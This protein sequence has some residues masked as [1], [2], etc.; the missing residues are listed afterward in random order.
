MVVCGG[1]HLDALEV[2]DD[3]WVEDQHDSEGHNGL[4]ESA[5]EHERVGVEADGPEALVVVD[6]VD[7][8]V[9]L[10]E[11]QQI[12]VPL[13]RRVEALGQ[14]EQVEG[15]DDGEHGGEEGEGAVLKH[16]FGLDGEFDDEPALHRHRRHQPHAQQRQRVVDV[17]EYVTVVRVGRGRRVVVVSI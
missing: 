15:E 16:A 17:D 11:E 6:L 12:G 9:A 14:V 2:V 3:E 8:V 1:G 7:E 10:A 5:H 13:R 4:E